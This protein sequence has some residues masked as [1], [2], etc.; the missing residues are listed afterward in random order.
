MGQKQHHY[1]L[2]SVEQLT[3]NLVARYKKSDLMS[4]NCGVSFYIL[5]S[6]VVRI[7]F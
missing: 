7:D 5:N 4:K 3:V 2:L 6:P 1:K